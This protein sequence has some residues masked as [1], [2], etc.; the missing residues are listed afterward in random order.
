MRMHEFD[1]LRKRLLQLDSCAVS[2]AMDHLALNGVAIGI[3]PQTVERKICG[4]V[5][6]VKLRVKAVGDSSKQHLGTAAIHTASSNEV[7]VVQGRGRENIS[8]WGGIL[9][10][11]AQHRGITGVIVD[12]ACRDVQECQNLNFPVYARAAVPVS[13]RGRLVEESFNQ[14]IEVAGI[15]VHP[16]DLVIADRNGVVFLP[17]DSAEQIIETAE[18]IIRRESEL[19]TLIDAGASVSEVLDSRFEDILGEEHG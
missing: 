14:P 7:I 18:E 15:T 6:T 9:S 3:Y 5:I 11:A 8:G 1:D 16:G 12:G 2:D 4:R 10:R 19:S 13:A 17:L